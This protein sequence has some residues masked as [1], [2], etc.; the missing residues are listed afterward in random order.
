MPPQKFETLPRVT[1][2]LPI[3]NERYVVERLLEETAKIDYPR[4]LLQIQVL[5][6]STDDTHPFTESLVQEYQA[7][8]AAD[9][10]HSSHQPRR[11][12]KPARYRTD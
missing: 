6:D 12:T 3:F 1:V 9:R 7:V 11:A 5:D 4:D 10:V 2:Q 8:R